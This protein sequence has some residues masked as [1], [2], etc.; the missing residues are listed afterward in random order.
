MNK[1][2]YHHG[3][4]RDTL[5]DTAHQILCEKGAHHISLREVTKITG[6]SH[7]ALYRHYTDK[8]ELLAELSGIGFGWLRDNLEK[9]AATY[10]SNP[11][12]Q[13]VEA[14]AVYVELANANPQMWELMFGGVLSSDVDLEH[15]SELENCAFGALLDIV[16]NGTSKGIYGDHSA[17][18]IAATT[19]SLAQGLAMLTNAGK[20]NLTDS[21]GRSTVT[22]ARTMANHLLRGIIDS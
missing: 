5:L 1:K 17:K 4:L 7:T 12:K 15:L 2:S 18:E 6:V 10:A 22:L 19:W 11:Q 13:L 14:C 16:E 21:T 9:V 20:L 3:N 8:Q